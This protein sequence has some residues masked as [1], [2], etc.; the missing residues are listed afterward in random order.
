MRQACQ[1]RPDISIFSPL[2]RGGSS[3]HGGITPVVCNLAAAF[4]DAGKRVELVTVTPADPRT[5]CPTLDGRIQVWNLGKGSRLRH[6]FQ[7]GTYLRERSPRVL[8]AAGQR[9]NLLAAFCIRLWRPPCRLFL[10]VHNSLSKGFDELGTVKRRLRILGMRASY[11]MADAVVCVSAGVA[12]DL[13]RYVNLP[14]RKVQVIHNPVLSPRQLGAIPQAPSHPWFEA[15]QPPV[16][17][18]AGRLT[19]Q[20]DFSSLI[21]A[22][23]LVAADHDCR[24]MILGEGRERLVLERL[25]SELRLSDRIA[26]PGFVADPRG[27]MAGASLFVLSSAWEGFGMVL[28]EAMAAGTPVVSTDCPSGPREILLDGALGPLVP[29]SD[30]PAL[31]RAMLQVLEA[32]PQTELL[33]RRAADFTSDQA[34]EKYLRLMFPTGQ[35]DYASS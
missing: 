25:A 8:L 33:R 23:A 9:P 1:P 34:A 24:L 7:L 6:L 5:L 11:P 22:F 19:R 21:R 28:V 2:G 10:S 15:G 20:K 26:L 18:G 13:A 17:L 31:A 14:E 29:V 30:P 3:T 16:I 32:P 4:A 27:F 35:G 12:D